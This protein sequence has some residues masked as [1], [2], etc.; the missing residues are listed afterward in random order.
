MNRL[1]NSVYL[2]IL[3]FQVPKMKFIA[4]ILTYIFIIASINADNKLR[5]V[6]EWK[7]FDFQF[8]DEAAKLD[9]ESK[10]HFTRGESVPIDIDVFYNGNL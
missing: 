7:E 5:L 8:P 4:E 3:F 10:N 2:E 9:A 6:Q 1:K